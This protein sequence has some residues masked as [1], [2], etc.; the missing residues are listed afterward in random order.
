[1]KP[2]YSSQHIMS[3][4][5]G[6]VV[7]VSHG[8]YDHVALLGDRRI[9]G[10]RSVISFSAKDGGFVEQPYSAFSLGRQVTSDGY[11]GGLPSAAVMQRARLKQGVPYSW[12]DFNCEHFVRYAHG[13]Q[14]ESPQVKQWVTLGSVA[15]FALLAFR[16]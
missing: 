13:V 15:C 8:W 11:F 14:I 2:E 6:T 1:M 12:I 9:N 3:L 16:G 7:R 4:P 10:E 5:T